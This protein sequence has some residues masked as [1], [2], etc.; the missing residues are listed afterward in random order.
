MRDSVAHLD[1]MT[2]AAFSMRRGN[3]ADVHGM[4]LLGEDDWMEITEQILDDPDLFGAW[5]EGSQR[6]LHDEAREPAERVHAGC[7]LATLATHTAGGHVLA[8]GTIPPALP[9]HLHETWQAAFDDGTVVEQ[10]V[11]AALALYTA[12]AGRASEAE[13]GEEILRRELDS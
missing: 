4:V 13:E 6:I 10:R 8:W 5:I 2:L 1:R 12:L 9:E 3:N 7:A 11:E